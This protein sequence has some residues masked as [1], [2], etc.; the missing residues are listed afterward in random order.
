MKGSESSVQDLI[1]QKQ[2]EPTVNWEYVTTLVKSAAGTKPGDR[3]RVTT[4]K[5]KKM[6]IVV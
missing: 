5:G 4:A 1:S 2:K 3:V 6:G